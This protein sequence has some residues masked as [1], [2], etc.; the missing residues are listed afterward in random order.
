MKSLALMY[1]GERQSGGPKNQLPPLEAIERRLSVAFPHAP[2][3]GRPV[4]PSTRSI[5]LALMV[6]AWRDYGFSDAAI[7]DALSRNRHRPYTEGALKGWDRALRQLEEAEG[8]PRPI[9]RRD[10]AALQAYEY[11][12]RR[13]AKA[14]DRLDAL[15]AAAGRDIDRPEIQ[16]AMS[17]SVRLQIEPNLPLTVHVGNRRVTTRGLETPLHSI[18]TERTL[19]DEPGDFAL[20]LGRR[21]QA[22]MR[23]LAALPRSHSLPLNSSDRTITGSPLIPAACMRMIPTRRVRSITP[24]GVN[25]TDLARSLRA[26]LVPQHV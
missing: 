5:R 21:C 10:S 19:S 22:S 17:R 1:I 11:A 26:R 24:R 23:T 13:W 18:V 3:R 12:N 9:I 8:R 20:P 2:S 14:A 6:R 7:L 4:G 15:L 16:A 25:G